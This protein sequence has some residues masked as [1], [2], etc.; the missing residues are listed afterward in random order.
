MRNTGHYQ[1]SVPHTQPAFKGLDTLTIKFDDQGEEIAFIVIGEDK[2]TENA[3]DTIRDE[4]WPSLKTF[5][6]GTR[7]SEIISNVTSLLEQKGLCADKVMKGI[8]DVFWL[9]QKRYHVA[10]TIKETHDSDQGRK[11]LFSDFDQVVP[12]LAARRT[13]TTVRFDDLRGWMEVLA[14]DLKNYILAL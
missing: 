8:E 5:E 2:A 14:T 6:D 4:V 9:D 11:R 12:G 7:N 3:R 13:A 10:I 1:T